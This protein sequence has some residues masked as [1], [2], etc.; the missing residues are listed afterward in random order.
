MVG[1]G[2]VFGSMRH[3]IKGRKGCDEESFVARLHRAV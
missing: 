3:R 2:M 1:V